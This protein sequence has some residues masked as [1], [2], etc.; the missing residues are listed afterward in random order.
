MLA[1]QRKDVTMQ[2]SVGFT[3][4]SFISSEDCLP[5]DGILW[6]VKVCMKG[7]WVEKARGSCLSFFSACEES[8]LAL[9]S[10]GFTEGL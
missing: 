10:L 9:L 8:R 4:M 1:P 6:I 3:K 7:V 2:W 5:R